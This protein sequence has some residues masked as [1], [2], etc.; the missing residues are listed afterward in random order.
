MVA[1]A[2]VH[3][4]AGTLT[5]I[6]AA[7]GYAVAKVGEAA[8]GTKAVDSAVFR[9][10]FAAWLRAHGVFPSVSHEPIA[11]G[12]SAPGI[13]EAETPVI[14]SNHISYL[15][16][17][18]LASVFGAP[19]IVSMAS[20]RKVPVIGKLMEEM[21]VIFVDRGD[22]GSKQATLD[23]IAEHC[24]TWVP[25]RRPLLIFPEGTTSNGEGLLDF[26]KGAFAAGVPVRPVLLVYTGQWDP[27]STSHKA[28]EHGLEEL[29]DAEWGAQFLGH[30][31]HSLEVR[32]LPPYVPT[33]AER[34]DPDL[35]AR[36]CQ[37]LMAEALARVRSEIQERS[38]KT[39]AGRSHGGLGYKFG[40]LTRVALRRGKRLFG[41]ADRPCEEDL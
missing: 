1:P 29:S 34:G 39:A 22:R 6:A 11:G 17:A 15:D 21:D 10:G 30:L 23:A 19:R 32:V 37:A 40:D 5:G 13:G 31:V 38:W 3:V 12:G 28:T 26:K 7:G 14:V 41:C 20:A 2:A 27:A 9:A 16:G 33:D 4:L 35:Y 36:N 18:V 8:G 24:A 25:G